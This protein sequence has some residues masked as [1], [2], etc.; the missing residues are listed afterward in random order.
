MQR[1]FAV[2]P[3]DRL[4]SVTTPT[5]DISFLEYLLPLISGASLYL[6]EAER[7]AD[8][9]RMISLI[10]DYQPTLMQATP[11][12]WH[13]LLTAG[14]RGD[15]QL[16]VLAGGEALPTKVAEELLRGCG[17]LWN[18]YGPTET[19]IW[20]LKA[21][22]TQAEYITLGAPIANTRVYI[23][24]EEGHP[25]PRGVDGE[26]YIAGDG[27]AHGYD[28]QPELSAQRFLSEPGYPGGRMFRTGDLVR[29]DVRGQLCFVGRKDSQ[30]KLRGYRI[31]LGEIERTLARHPHV[32]G[33]VVACI[34][35]APLHK[36][37][38]AFIVTNAPLSLFEQLKNDLRQQLPDYMVPTLW[39]RVTAFPNT[40]NGKIDRK[41]L[42][43]DFVAEEPLAPPPALSDAEQ[44]L[45]ALWRRYLPITN[46][47][48][49]CDFF[50]LGGTPCWRWRWWPRSTV[51]FTVP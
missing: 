32:D 48:P 42:A 40:A 26:L 18:L 19:T 41:R 22:I 3:N 46:A 9:F 49:E 2:G 35:S 16:C 12:F 5:F 31:E 20:S 34:E 43:A 44:A 8:S 17:A 33:A 6:T 47:G 13:G 27:V 14:W 23:L 25:V 7:A 1:T 24:D 21:Q 11:S 15:P 45:L 38:A 4:L 50:R 39:Q 51:P 36:A 29:C 28:G 37:L 30:I 10:A